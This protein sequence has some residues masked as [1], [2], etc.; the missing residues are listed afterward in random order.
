M[1]ISKVGDTFVI[2]NQPELTDNTM[3]AL[4]QLMH[5]VPDMASLHGLVNNLVFNA[6]KRDPEHISDWAADYAAMNALQLFL[7]ALTDHQNSQSR[8][9]QID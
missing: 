1:A 7:T 9:V 4:I 5:L 8:I 2:H 6:V 3:G